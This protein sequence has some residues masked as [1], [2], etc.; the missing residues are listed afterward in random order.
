MQTLY[1]NYTPIKA[2]FNIT[3]NIE[4]LN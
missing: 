4:N 1:A 3:Y 2:S